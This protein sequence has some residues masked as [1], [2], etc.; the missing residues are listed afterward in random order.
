MQK[1]ETEV[2]TFNG[3]N[4][5]SVSEAV[6][7]KGAESFE[8]GINAIF[9]YI[10]HVSTYSEFEIIEGE[11]FNCWNK[12]FHRL[13]LFTRKGEYGSIFFNTTEFQNKIKEEDAEAVKQIFDYFN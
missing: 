6:E 3:G 5:S 8:S 4:G 2:I 10:K 13:D 1:K 11:T 7:I 12:I 9:D